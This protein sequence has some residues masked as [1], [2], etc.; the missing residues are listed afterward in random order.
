MLGAHDD[1]VSRF[2]PKVLKH[3]SRKSW[4]LAVTILWRNCSWNLT[5]H[6]HSGAIDLVRLH[7]RE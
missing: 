5:L 2:G 3:K 6:E 7:L 1:R 4:Y